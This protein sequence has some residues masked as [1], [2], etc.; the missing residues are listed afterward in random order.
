[1]GL[2]MEGKG[3]GKYLFGFMEPQAFLKP[4]EMVSKSYV[5]LNPFSSKNRSKERTLNEGGN[6]RPGCELASLPPSCIQQAR[7]PS[8]RQEV[9]AARESFWSS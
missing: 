8:S 5:S 4:G 1:M 3:W 7:L 6:A 2:E 9:N